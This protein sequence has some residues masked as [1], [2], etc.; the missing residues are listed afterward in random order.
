M[1]YVPVYQKDQALENLVVRRHAVVNQLTANEAEIVTLLVDNLAVNTL[2]VAS[3]FTP[4]LNNAHLANLTVD[5]L[6]V[7]SQLNMIP[8]ATINLTTVTRD[9]TTYEW[10][11]SDGVP[12]SV[13]STNGSGVLSFTTS[14][15][16]GNVTANPVFTT[17]HAIPRTNTTLSSTTI[18]Q[19]GLV[20]SNT[21]DLSVPGQVTASQFNGPLNGTA[22][23]SVNFTGSLAGEVQGPQ[24]ATVVDHIGTQSSAQIQ[25]GVAQ[26]N[27]ATNANTANTIVKRDSAGAFSAGQITATQFVGPLTGN[28]TG[29]ATSAT[30]ATTSGSFSGTL[31]GDVSGTQT[32]THVDT[33][34]GQNYVTIGTNIQKVSDAVS[35]T[36]NNTLVVRNNT[37]GFSGSVITADTN[38][39]GPL[40]GNASSATVATTAGTATN[41]SGSLAGDVTGTQSATK[42][43]QVQNDAKTQTVTNNAIVA[44]IQLTQTATSSS[45]P[46]SLVER[47]ASSNFTANAITADNVTI[48]GSITNP[49]DA[50]TK[51][52]VD[53]AV[54][55]GAIDPKQSVVALAAVPITLSGVPQTIDGVTVNAGD[56]VLVVNQGNDGNQPNINNGIWVAAVGAWIRPA[57][58]ANGTTAGSAYVLV[59]TPVTP[60]T[61][62][63]SSWLCDTPMAVIGTDPIGFAQFTAPNSTTAANVGTGFGV[64]LNKTSN[65]LNF[66]SLNPG[67]VTSTHFQI[68]NGGTTLNLSTDGTSANTA[69]TL[70]AR[71][72]S[73]NFSAGTITASLTGAA[74]LNVLKAGDTMTGPLTMANQSAILWQD[75]GSNSVG[76]RAPTTVPT[77]YLMNWP[78]A[79]PSAGQVLT[80]TSTTDTSWKNGGGTLLAAPRYIFVS[81]GGDDTSGNGSEL[82]PYLTVFKAVQVAIAAPVSLSQPIVISVGPGIYV[83]SAMSIPSGSPGLSIVGS[84]LTGTTLRPTDLTNPLFTWSTPFFEMATLTV[85]SGNLSSSTSS[86]LLINTATFGNAG[87]R[88]MLITNFQLGVSATCSFALAAILI[89]AQFQL[90]NNT[91]GIMSTNTRLIMENCLTLGPV[92]GTPTGTAVQCIGTSN[93]A[94]I[95]SSTFRNFQL[96]TDLKSNSKNRIVGCIFENNFIDSRNSG[97]TDTD[98]V[99]CS[100]INNPDN[101]AVDVIGT[102]AGT[103]VRITGTSFEGNSSTATGAC[104]QC[105]V[106]ASVDLSACII[107]RYVSGLICGTNADTSTTA[108]SASDTTI[109]GCTSDM[110]QLGTSSLIFVGAP[111]SPSGVS[112]NNATNCYLS[113]FD[114]TSKGT[115]SIGNTTNVSQEVYQILNSTT[116]G[117]YPMLTYEPNYYSLSGTVYKEV[118]ATTDALTALQSASGSVYD[119]C[120][121]GD[122]TKIAGLRLISDTS[123]FGVPDN[124]RGW[125]MWKRGTSGN[126]AWNYVNADTS[127]QS[128]LGDNTYMELNGVLNTL[129]FPQTTVTP[130]PSNTY[131][132]LVWGVPAENTNLYRSSAG[133]LKTDGSFSIA[134]NATVTGFI[135]NA[136]LTPSRAVVTDASDNLVSS[137]TTATEIGFVS[138]V[139]SSIQTQLNSKLPSGGGT[140]TGNLT[141]PL[142]TTT[143]P[144]LN[145]TGFP[146]TGLS[147]GA[148]TGTLQLSTNGVGQVLINGSTGALTVTN[149]ATGSAGVVHASSAGILSN[150]LIVGADIA[151]NTIPDSALQ[152]ITTSGKV[153]NSATTAAFADTAN[154]IVSRDASGNFSAGTITASLSGNATTATTATNFSGSLGGAVTGT[155][156][157]TALTFLKASATT[158]ATTTSLTFVQMTSMT[159]TP[160]AGTYLLNFNTYVSNTNANQRISISVFSG[161]T[162]ITEANRTVTCTAGNALFSIGTTTS[163]TV[164]GTQAIEIRWFTTA[165]TATAN[166]RVMT[167]V[168]TS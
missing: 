116:A 20:V 11:T 146:G 45:V 33:V 82:A 145:F 67:T 39:V 157:A 29:N 27:L 69:S 129:N 64:F 162:Q 30:T 71:D 81:K 49:T 21:N 18:E 66:K 111:F 25:S 108:L 50:T 136:S 128:A 53:A 97:A 74:S 5:T 114:T 151:T 122:N 2:E 154:A 112:I 156:S 126:L 12:G 65:T 9:G 15:G 102:D 120:I 142:G 68:T 55:T 127:G 46:N 139:T 118:R 103:I 150:S 84:S 10:P 43:S 163:T 138:G 62:G 22:S 44:G 89:C 79:P 91:T 143:N 4:N 94:S 99:G 130:I 51:Q 152:A 16:G 160:V 8:P 164:D 95:T 28:V 48:N 3:G 90:V 23:S 75:T 87:L 155:Q 14:A 73:G 134:Q 158:A 38:F 59:D 167:L 132:Q 88:T 54:A 17:N 123:A 131:T 56:R 166:E 98:I 41:F 121:T 100:F 104:I 115:L 83:E 96:A 63:G 107:S 137:A 141:L 42:V 113:A 57:D 24:T 40:V 72:G 70:V 109:Q 86:A 7:T 52:Y 19:T 93:L 133:L 159:L 165:N 37:G 140:L 147:A 78:T 135:N 76:W 124:V 58:F 106:G 47:D 60:N 85:D 26:A 119:Y 77:S 110:T 148:G 161:G 125:L 1:S 117:Q 105:I 80:A 144:S 34:G 32:T 101:T 6:N 92:T 13:L 61:Y 149:L 31:A 168:R 153:A 36:S 35:T